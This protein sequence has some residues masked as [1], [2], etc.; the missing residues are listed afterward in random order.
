MG[1]DPILK[2][3]KYVLELLERIL[4]KMDEI[5]RPRGRNVL[6]RLF[7]P[8]G[9]FAGQQSAAKEA[10]VMM[11]DTHARLEDMIQTLSRHNHPLLG[12]IVELKYLDLKSMSE[13]LIEVPQRSQYMA[14]QIDELRIKVKKVISD[15]E[16]KP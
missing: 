10:S 1:D 14:S 9:E 8:Y 13:K 4:D 3:L 11:L 5:G 15:L 16:S 7:F 12:T 2:Q 6:W